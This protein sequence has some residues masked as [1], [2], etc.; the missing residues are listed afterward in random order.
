[1]AI[2]LRILNKLIDLDEKIEVLDDSA[3]TLGRSSEND[4]VLKDERCSGSHVEID[5]A[6]EE[7]WIRDLDS[8]NG[9]Y[10]DK[11]R[12]DKERM[13]IG[14][15]LI[16][17]ETKITLDSR[18]MSEAEKKKYTRKRVSSKGNNK[19]GDLSLVDGSFKFELT[20]GGMSAN[21]DN[22][23]NNGKRGLDLPKRKKKY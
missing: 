3:I 15:Q 8:K 22:E 2:V 10:V 23:Y 18:L 17:G 9:T 5:F 1:M 11:K 14:T 19:V 7:I 16:V 6:G 13:Y 4:Y 12:V 20:N 21:E